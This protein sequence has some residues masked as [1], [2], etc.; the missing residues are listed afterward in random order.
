MGDQGKSEL[1]DYVT[2]AAAHLTTS[3]PYR[4]RKVHLTN[5]IGKYTPPRPV[6]HVIPLKG[7]II[8]ALHQ[9]VKSYCLSISTYESKLFLRVLLG[10]MPAH[11][12]ER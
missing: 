5:C 7:P 11:T 10:R 9:S 4:E 1:L 3:T 2:M 6:H 8:H 12:S